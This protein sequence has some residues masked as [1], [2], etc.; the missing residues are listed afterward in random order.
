MSIYKKEVTTV[1][2]F[3]KKNEHYSSSRKYL[4]RGCENKPPEIFCMSR[5]YKPDD[6][7]YPTFKFVNYAKNTTCG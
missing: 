3:L 6:S 4:F 5:A 2:P 1:T 7:I